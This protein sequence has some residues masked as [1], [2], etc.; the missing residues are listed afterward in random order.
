M[1]SNSPVEVS[2]GLMIER[3]KRGVALGLDGFRASARENRVWILFYVG[4]AGVLLV[5]EAARQFGFQSVT[6]VSM[7]LVL[8]TCVTGCGFLA[9]PRSWRLLGLLIVAAIEALLLTRIIPFTL[10]D[11]LIGPGVTWGTAVLVTMLF[12]AL[13]R[14]YSFNQD[15]LPELH[16][17]Q[18]QAL[19]FFAA[20][21]ILFTAVSL[22]VFVPTR[23][24]FG[25]C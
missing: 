22:L 17:I 21:I 11:I 12:S 3:V 16:T 25:A 4:F 14:F 2:A 15:L 1:D 8:G 24:E 10:R 13:G 6:A 9:K 7:A 23:L 19:N 18:K 20:V 5:V